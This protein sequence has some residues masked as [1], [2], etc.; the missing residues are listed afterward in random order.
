MAFNNADSSLT[1]PSGA[2]PDESQIVIGDAIPP[3]LLVFYNNAFRE[4]KAVIL[5]RI[6]SKSYGY[7]AIIVYFNSTTPYRASGIVNLD[8]SPA[9][10]QVIELRADAVNDTGSAVTVLGGDDTGTDPDNGRIQFSRYAEFFQRAVFWN[11]VTVTGNFSAS[12]GISILPGLLS[13]ESVR[14]IGTTGMPPFQNSWSNFGGGYVGARFW[15]DAHGVIHADGMIKPGVAWAANQVM[16]SLFGISGYV[17]K[18]RHVFNCRG[19]GGSNYR[20][21]VTTNGDFLL[22]DSGP[23][24]GGW[25]SLQGISFRSDV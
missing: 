20:V 7:D 2:T 4:I 1:I 14:N 12:G 13:L 19:N 6:D 17:P 9:I 8:R 10:D 22:P 3:E 18:S 15:S 21:D 11:N 5:Y 16:F 24:V 25:I 23:A